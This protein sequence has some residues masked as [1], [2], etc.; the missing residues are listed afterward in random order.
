M[1]YYK[2]FKFKALKDYCIYS[3]DFHGV[4]LLQDDPQVLTLSIANYGVRWI[5]IEN[6]SSANVIFY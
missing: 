3:L 5:L 2:K 1:R 6:G 4:I